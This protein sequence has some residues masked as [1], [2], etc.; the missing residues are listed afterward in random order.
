MKITLDQFLSETN[1]FDKFLILLIFL[2]PILLC[3]S[4]F[5]ADLSASIIALSTIYLYC[6]K[7]NKELFFE[8]KTPFYFFILF[9][10]LIILSLIFSFSFKDSFLP[11]FFYFR[12]FLFAVGIY[13]FFEKYHFFSKIIFYSLII[14]F[15]LVFLDSTKQY[16]I[17]TNFFNKPIGIDPTP[18]ITGFFGNEKKLGSFLVRLLPLVLSILYF[19]NF[20]KFDIYIIILWGVFIFLSSERTALFL[21]FIIVLFSFLINK[22]KLK[23]LFLCF[24]IFFTLFTFHEKL[25]FKY[26]DYTLQQLGF[27]DTE[28]NKVNDGKI[29]YYSKEHEDLSYTALVIFKNNIFNGSGI[30]TFYKICNQFKLKNEQKKINKFNFLERNNVIKCS[31]HP[32]NTYF[33]ILSEIGIFGFLMVFFLFFKTLF[34]N[35]KIFFKKNNNN[36]ALSFYFLN[37]GIMINIFPLIPSGS[38][39]NNWISLILF[40]P[41]GFWLYMNKKYNEKK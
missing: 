16:L 33:Q 39:F 24:L 41:L 35:L 4:I 28:W 31:T 38:I 19:L 40:Y 26:I 13:Y 18:F 27:A 5:L 29:R 10:F 30:K 36:V 6:S 20:K 32:H 2:F 25:R 15:F 37:V 11:S 22:K 3:N 34:L 14:T 1:Y 12:Y 9:Y 7:K 21:Y 23:F 17:G 8:I